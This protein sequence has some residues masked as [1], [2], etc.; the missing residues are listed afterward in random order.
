ME[1]RE[2]RRGKRG[3]EGREEEREEGCTHKETGWKT[4]SSPVRGQHELVLAPIG[5]PCLLPHGDDALPHP[6]LVPPLQIKPQQIHTHILL[7]HLPTHNHR[8]EG[9]G[10]REVREERGEGGER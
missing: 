1:E 8:D 2:E 7:L 6:P 5:G 10:R 4:T 9:G 3:G